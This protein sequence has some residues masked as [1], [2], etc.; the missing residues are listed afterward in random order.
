MTARALNSIF[1]QWRIS[2]NQEHW[3]ISGELCS[4]DAIA[5]DTTDIDSS[6]GPNPYIKC[7]CTYNNNTL[8]H[9]TRLKVY[10]LNVVGVIPEELW[11][12][13]FL[14][15]LNLD[16]NYLTGPLSASVGNLT[17]MQYFT[18][19]INALSGELPKE[20][21][22]MTDMRSFG[23]GS[24]NFSGP[25]PSEL[26]NWVKLEQ[27]YIDSSGV[28][29]EIPSTFAKLQNMATMWAS[30]TELT[31][32]IPDFIGNWSK[33]TS[34]S[35]QGN[36]FDG[37][38]PSS[39]SN[40]TALTKLKISDLSNGSSTLSF[41]KDMKS[42][43]FLEL[44]N[45]NISDSIPSNIG[46]FQSLQ[47]LD[48]SFNNLGGDIPNSLFNLSSL[49]NLFL[50]NNRLNGTLPTQ[51]ITTLH[52]I[53]VSYNN[54]IGSFPSWIN[55]PNLQLNVVAN[56]LTI[57]SS[58]SSLNSALPFGLNCLQ[59][60]FPCNRGQGIYYNFSIKAGGPQITSS[61]GIVFERDNETLGPASY[62]VTGTTRWG[63]NRVQKDF[64]IKKEAGGAS[65]R[66]VQRLFTARVSENYLEIH[67]FWAGKGTCCIPAQ[68]TYGPS[69]SAIS[70]IPNFIPSVSNIPP[71]S[72]KKNRTGLIAGIVVGVGLLSLLSIIAILWIVRRRNRP[73]DDDEVLLGIDVKPY[74]FSYSGK[75]SD[76]RE[77]AVKQ[78]SVA[79]HQGKSQFVAEIVA[80]SAVQHRNLVKLYGCCIEGSERLLVYEYL[81]NKSL[82]QALF[83]ETSLN[84]NWSTRYDIC[85]GVA[86]GLAYL[87]EESRLRI[88]HRDVKASNILL[89]YELNPKISDFGL[90]KLYDD[91]KTHISTRVAGTIG[92]LAPEYAMRG[93]LTEKTDVFAFGVVALEIVSGRPNSDSSLDEEQI[94]LLEW[95]WNLHE[96]NHQ[97]ELVD[98]KL[99]EF[100][101][102][103]VKRMIGVALLCTQTLPSLR[104]P[105]S[106][107]VAMLCGDMEVSPVTTKPGYLND[108]KY[109][110]NTTTG[111]FMSSTD[112]AT[113]GT[114]YNSNFTS[115]ST[116]MVADAQHS[117]ANVTKPI[118]HDI[119]GEVRALNS[120][121]Q[122]WGISANQDQWNISGEPCS[123]AA[124]DSTSY[125]NDVY[126]PFIKC[127]CTYNNNTLCHITR[128]KVYALDVVGMI[129]D[130]LWTLTFLTNLNLGQ[131]YL[132]GPLSASIGNLTRMQYFTV[133]INALSGEL[134]KELGKMTDIRSFGIGSNNFS[135][136]LPS[137]LGNWMKLEQLYIDSSGV[138]GEIPST[139]A[140]LQNMATMWASDTELTGRIPDFIG[141]WSKLT[142]LRFHGNSF[143]GPI[144]SSFSKLTALTELKISDLSNGSSTLAFMK[145]MKSLSFLE[146]RNNNISDSIPSN[147]GEYRSLKH[148]DL[149]FN[150]LGGEIP[151]SLF[152][153]SSLAILFLGNN[154]LNS[155]LPPQKNTILLNIDVSYNNLI[156]SFPSWI[157]QPNLQLNVVANNLTIDNSNSSLSS[158]LPFGLNCLQR[159]FPCYRGAGIYYNFSIK[160]GGPQ[161]TSSNGIVYERENATL[162]PA[163][164]FVTDTRRWGVSNVGS[165]AENNN[166]RYISSSSSQFTNTLDSE[167]FHTAR[168]SASSLRYYGLGLENGDYNV[169][170]Q[171]AEM[172]I[173]DT[174]SWQ[175]VGRRVFDI[176]IQGNRVRK[177][178][179]IKNEAGGVSKSAVQMQFTAQ[180]SEN[181]L[182]IHLF[183]AGK[184]TCCIPTQRTYGPSISAIS[185]TP[186]F[187]PSVSNIPPTSPKKNRTGLIAGIVVGVGLLSLLSVIAI[188][189]I[190]RRR[191]RPRDDDEVLLGIDAKPYTFSHS[192][193]KTATEDFSPTNKLGEGGFGAVYKGK[194]SDGRAIAVKQLSVASQQGKSQFVA[195]IVAISAV[196]HRNLVKLYGC[197]IEGSERLLVY[198]YLENKSLDQ[199][200]FGE[201]SLNFNW[202][203][204]YDICLGVARGLAYLHEESRLRIIHRDVKAS[205]ILLDYE[206]NPKISDFG[207]AKLYDDKKTHISTCV[208][209]TIGY[210]APE[211]AMRGH[212]TEKTDVFAFGV[213]ALEI[214]SG[215]PNSDSSLDEE[216][217]YLLEWAW[218]L[219]ENNRQ[220]E[221][222]DSRLPEFNE[223]VKRMIGVALLCTQT[224]PS[225]RPPMS[226]VVAMLYGDMEVSPVTTKPGYLTDW[227]YD[228]TSTASSFMSSDKATIG[229]EYNS[230]FTSSSTTV[231][232]D[233]Q[234][235]PANVT[236]PILHDIIG[237]VR[238]LNSIFQQWGIS[239]NQDQWNISGQPCSGAAIDST[240]FDNNVYNPFIKC[241]CSYNNNTLCH[242]TK[243][244]VYALDVV[245]VIPD[246]LWTLTF[247]V[248]LNLGKNYLT[249]PLSASIRNLTAM[250]YMSFD[251]NALSG[252][253]PKELGML[254]E[255][256]SLSVAS[257]NF[258]GSLPLE[259][260]NLMKLQQLYISSSGVTGE[261]PSSFA[262]LQNLLTVWAS[263]VELTGRIPDF[264]GNW[265]K[266]DSLRFQGNSFEGPIPSSF[267][268]LTTL[269]ELRISDLSNG[270]SS[271][272]F[273]R[274]M[275]SL[276]VLE[277]R[278]NNISDSIP[279][280]IGEYQRLQHLDLSFNNIG[281]D[282]HDSLFNLSSLSRLFLGNNKLN[283][284]LP[285]QKSTSLLNIDVSYNNL[286]GSLPSWINERNLQLNLV[287]N[288]LTIDTSNSSA[289]PFGLNCLQRNFPC[290][291]GAGIY[292]NFSIKCGGPQIT[293]SNGIV[294]ERDNTTLGP[295]S[296]FVTNTCRWGVSNVGYFT[297]SNNPQYTTFSKSQF[298]NTLDSELFQTARI[299]ASSLR[300][301]GLG[302]E[303]GNYNVTLQFTEMDILDTT[304]W[305]SIGRRKFDIY[306]Q[307]NH[308]LKDFDIKKEAGEIS[309]KAV[310][311]QF[312]A[313]VSENYLEIHLFWAGKGTCC[314]PNQGTYGPS[315]SA[316]SATPD[317]IPTVSNNPPTS[318][319][320]TNRTGLIVGIVV[321]V[322]LVS[323][324]LA[325]ILWIIQR[326][327]RPSKDDDDVLQGIDAKPYTFSYA[328]LKTATEDFSPE[329]KLGEGGFGPV[330]KGKLDD[331][332]AIAVKQL[333]V[334]SQQGKSQ[335]VAEIVAISAVQHRNLVKLYG[336]CIEGSKRLLVYEYLQNRSLDQAI[337]GMKIEHV[338]C[339]IDFL[340]NRKSGYLAPEYAMRGHL[341]EKTDVF[342]FGVV[343]LEVVSGR[344]NSDSSLDEEQV[345]LLEWA[346]HLHE[347]NQEAELVDSRL[348]EFNEEEVKR[349]IAVAL[350]CT[351]TLPSLRPPMSRV[352][353]ML[354]GDMEVSTVTTKPG[355]LTDWKYDGTT[356]TGSFVSSTDKATIG[357]DTSNYTSSTTTSMVVVAETHHSAETDTEPIL[358]DN[359]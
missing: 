291:R 88:I 153:M 151:E 7:V 287:A 237:D 192:V 344:P 300:Y 52:N 78:L 183:W 3:N 303:N 211:Y 86:R 272:E 324:L 118:L 343:A 160:A 261:I 152:N 156:G 106:R 136:P 242:I 53:D 207:L 209:G 186:N 349:L 38:I 82:D 24:N 257:N 134:P 348:P 307:G 246:E 32:R 199:A 27:L 295:S 317:F 47:H 235:S 173:L 92:Y 98:S 270:S 66:A 332:R 123:G 251:I 284:T 190:V 109:D 231:V 345:Y 87:H 335:F 17:R 233:A 227:K 353:A 45:N 34:L 138:S 286:I 120:I 181:Y 262:N 316:I 216:Q 202:S 122:Q 23:I 342:A 132:T 116:T 154:K 158:A 30:D 33:L 90:A 198:E 336:C 204:R 333:S 293:S 102:E 145:D 238:A 208:A 219:H 276:S 166:P 269:T 350:L 197:C 180:V 340:G 252:E 172:T 67:L 266:L 292:Y 245:G 64:D 22:N 46:E 105:M 107:V 108:W 215:R 314:I 312:K 195:E 359:L 8:C 110:D 338:C 76:E 315:I 140:K 212:L 178:F 100:N 60:N 250:Q 283:G 174:T 243:L 69:I 310:Q 56:N 341:T 103:E 93:H 80:I 135:G 189:W 163:S 223:E 85:L 62:F 83:G 94:Y 218:N 29:G 281:G 346:W 26:G 285:I 115:S 358:Y 79:S 35:F 296:Y 75:L 12:L 169:T 51:K 256:I 6:S 16:Q 131:N 273:I 162:G 213:V 182:E 255:L 306:I 74:T 31:G 40:L 39:F 339:I 143:D 55:Q 5:T 326:R 20:L 229:T 157:N 240:S 191:N 210:L 61:D 21:G 193:L 222:V 126:N 49:T 325:A 311:K 146:L 148:L 264:I 89:D 119:I 48:L 43:S 159:N 298:T 13:T 230:N 304:S 176:Y 170:L 68:G 263:D 37:P 297:G 36:S 179:N 97:V 277:L 221:L 265:S 352:V 44:R 196:Q 305:E 301:Y 331:G 200:L 2:A 125:V 254:T 112:N 232:A 258:S 275:K 271:L 302:L 290:N 356:T 184:G 313:Q 327:K 206:L 278:N 354:C 161:I 168:I 121:F 104:P 28:S 330:Y 70:A 357:I 355:Y 177:D 351:Q 294:Y 226:H 65:K 77:I 142:S 19:G 175:S 144:P 337:F 247:L 194:L 137:E 279:S 42:L 147:I 111:S 248:D 72:P 253:L 259:L 9:I 214:V 187:I 50:G 117:P 15:N 128:L 63:G 309:E 319:S 244:K 101:E 288:N 334:A 217:M 239:A 81:E 54:L 99:P 167:L 267:S 10:A 241:V 171:F 224:M 299:S 165:F 96:N 155:T 203:T 308:V 11:T 347:N 320:K 205:N 188:L 225:L 124:I 150:N 318:R 323:F 328:V 114:E 18:V 14:T 289:L 201:T 57:D 149:S 185:A 274:E 58:N 41:L 260:G 133:G 141:N 25:L 59:R 95:A 73:R 280:N 234:H 329:N 164:Y 321:G 249:G 130:E 322:G 139:L 268:N 1:Q 129:P 236:K 91:K 282:I 127:V 4:G 71:T 228:D 220:V 84:F 113:I